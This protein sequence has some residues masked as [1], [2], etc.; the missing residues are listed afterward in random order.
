MGSP[1]FEGNNIFLHNIYPCCKNNL[2]YVETTFFQEIKIIAIL[3]IV[4]SIWITW[5]SKMS[6]NKN[7]VV[8]T[9]S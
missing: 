9:I 5:K 1:S 6:L 8:L 4:R 2:S 3:L 7:A